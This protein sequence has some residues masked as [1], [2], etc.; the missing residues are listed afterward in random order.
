MALNNALTNYE[1]ENPVEVLNSFDEE[2]KS[3]VLS[4]V[5]SLNVHD[6]NAIIDYG[7]ESSNKLRKYTHSILEST[8]VRDNPEVENLMLTLV[9]ELNQ[10]DAS[11]LSERKVGFLGKLFKRDEV[12]TLLTKYE[13]VNGVLTEVASKL[14]KAKFE[15]R[16]DV[17]Q[18]SRFAASTLEYIKDLDEDILVLKLKLFELE[19]QIND[20]EL[21]IDI[22]DQLQ[23]YEL[24]ELKASYNRLEKRAYD[25]TLIRA[26]SVTMLPQLKM[27]RDGNEVLIDKI[28]TSITTAIPIWESQITLALQINRQKNAQ[29][30]NKAVADKTNEL[31][32]MNSKLLKEGSIAIAKDMER[33]VI[34]I[35]SIRTS[36]KSI[37]ET[38]N[39]VRSIQAKG[40]E[41]RRK[42]IEEMR[43]VQN[44]I[45]TSFLRLEE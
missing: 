21:K 12:K 6:S 15:L 22:N 3:R 4:R 8:K 18:C 28:T 16:K 38:I 36:A 2:L 10:V 13:S 45:N 31:I 19:K 43:Q 5:D 17:E 7:V 11:S 30:I 41:E 34:D 39:E 33:G 20:K 42:G 23:V 26:A 37:V 35:E 29:L 40:I 44:Q 25:L 32:K 9:G 1:L 27:I 24:D 14:D